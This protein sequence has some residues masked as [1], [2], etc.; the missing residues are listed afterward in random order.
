MT[1]FRQKKW[2][3]Q[4]RTKSGEGKRQKVEMEKRNVRSVTSSVKKGLGEGFVEKGR[5]GNEKVKR[6]RKK[7][8]RRRFTKRQTSRM[9]MRRKKLKQQVCV[10]GMIWGGCPPGHC[11]PPREGEQSSES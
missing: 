9:R 6:K 11:P 5:C 7:D 8:G 2:I 1:S 4:R 3:E 10:P